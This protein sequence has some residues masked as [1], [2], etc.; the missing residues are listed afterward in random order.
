MLFPSSEHGF[1]PALLEMMQDIFAILVF[2]LGN[3]LLKCLLCVIVG[4]L[5]VVGPP[6]NS[7]QSASLP[8]VEV[9]SHIPLQESEDDHLY[10]SIL[11]RIDFIVLSW[12][13]DVM[14]TFHRHALLQD[15]DNAEQKRLL[16]LYC[17]SPR[18][19]NHPLATDKDQSQISPWHGVNSS[20][21]LAI[22]NFWLTLWPNHFS[23]ALFSVLSGYFL[24][25]GD[26][27]LVF[28]ANH[29]LLSDSW[30][31]LALLLLR[32]MRLAS[33]SKLCK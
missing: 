9:I 13:L 32:N 5:D 7:W 25:I 14:E 21:H 16:L 1:Q 11:G 22:C 28:F 30:A 33:V 19:K 2:S 3:L 27:L 31:S 23:L 8:F 20:S 10:V 6:I 18:F 26:A 15:V 29:H 24:V 12:T 4:L 17:Y